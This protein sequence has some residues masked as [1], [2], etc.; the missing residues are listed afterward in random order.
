MP[1]CG[2][3]LSICC[4]C[5]SVWGIIMLILLGVFF[6]IHSPALADDLPI[7]QVEW[8]KTIPPYSMDYVYALYDQASNN[9]FI[10]AGIYVGCFVFS[11]IQHHLN[12][13]ANYV[14]S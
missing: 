3:K 2:P 12:V 13:R 7:D 11:Y 6:R 8:A 14:M 9:C 1:L 5:L 10:A 4:M